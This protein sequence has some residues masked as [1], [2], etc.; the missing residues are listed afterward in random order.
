MA[1]QSKPVY[2]LLAES[3]HIEEV[4]YK[5]PMVG[6]T[7]KEVSRALGETL[8]VTDAQ[9]LPAFGKL[10]QKP[11]KPCWARFGIMNVS[12]LPFQKEAYCKNGYKDTSPAFNCL[13]RSFKTLRNN[14][15]ICPDCRQ[16]KMVGDIQRAI[17]RD[18]ERRLCKVSRKG[19]GNCIHLVPCG[20]VASYAL[21]Q[22]C[23]APGI[24]RLGEV[25]HPARKQWRNARNLSSWLDRLKNEVQQ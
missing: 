7:G 22:V 4:R 16:T 8:G 9:E 23:L 11:N 3:P 25:P 19:Q 14:M 15:S 12:R 5:C 18:L 13:M 21:R 6:D 1:Q 2:I 10:L 20:H 24:I 17:L